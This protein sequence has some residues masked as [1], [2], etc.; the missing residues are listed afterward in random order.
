MQSKLRLPDWVV[1]HVPHDATDIPASVRDQ[2][3]LDDAT[4][5]TELCRMTDHLTHALFAHGVDPERV[6]RAPVSRLVVDVERFEDDGEE[7]MAARGM[8]VVYSKT[9]YGLPLRRPL[10]ATERQSLLD[11]YYHPHHQRLACAVDTALT[12]HGRCLVLDCHSFARDALPY[13]RAPVGQPRPEICIGTDGHHTPAALTRALTDAFLAEGFTVALNTPFAG[14][15]VPLKHYGKTAALKAAMI[16][17]RRDLYC[18]ESSGA[19]LPGFD[20]VRDRI[21]RALLSALGFSE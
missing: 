16:E 17:V 5:D 14:A 4:L 6:V 12:T 7:P 3:A 19:V 2:F 11:T 8:G 20:D 9:S 10:I 15:L 18:D 13:E 1:L 21:R